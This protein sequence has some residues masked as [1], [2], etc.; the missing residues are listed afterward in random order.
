MKH[1]PRPS[2][3]RIS[4]APGKDRLQ[5]TP[6]FVRYAFFFALGAAAVTLVNLSL[7][8]ADQETSA[9]ID[10]KE[11]G[12]YIASTGLIT[13]TGRTGTPISRSKNV[14]DLT[15]ANLLSLTDTEL[16]N[17]DPLVMNLV[18]A[19]E[20][21]ELQTIDIERYAKIVDRWAQAIQAGLR[22]FEPEARRTD[23]LYTQNPQLWQA[24]SMSIA[25]AGPRI[26]IAYTA[27]T[28]NAGDPGQ[29][30][31]PGL[32][33]NKTGTCSSMP[34][35]YLAIAHRLGWPLKAVVSRDHFWCRWDD[36]VK[37][38]NLE[39]TAASS[40]GSIGSFTSTSDEDYIQQLGTPKRAIDSGSDFTSLTPRQLLGVFLQT[41]AAYW[42]AH[43]QWERAEH[44]LLLAR[45]CFP[46]NRDIFGFLLETMAHRSADIFTTTERRQLI[47]MFASASAIAERSHRPL[48]GVPG[49]TQNSIDLPN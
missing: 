42:A 27:D 25:V 14:S 43:K 11:P 37:R 46:R 44:D 15:T 41:R 18:V 35:L 9:S 17:L 24:G 3:S 33:D 19:K 1:R 7:G 4:K 23:P 39:A 20:V 34:V 13:T 5:R 47:S 49:P 2:Q 38:F 12:R 40:D 8:F 31:L 30:F 6:T 28:L 45:T 29:L 26:G 48:R 16:A 32:I 22:A 21:P 36:G 10:L